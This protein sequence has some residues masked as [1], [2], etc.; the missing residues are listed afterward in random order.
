VNTVP[1]T[2]RVNEAIGALDEMSALEMLELMNHEDAGVPVAV[3]REIPA[4]AQAVDALTERL[5]ASG[6][7]ILVG[8][9]TSGRL[10]LMQTAEARP[11]FGIAVGT[12]VGIMAGGAD[13]MV[14]PAEAAEDD[15]AAGEEEL[16]RVAVDARDGVI[17]ISA[18]GRTHFVVGALTQARRS[19]ALT[20]GLSCDHPSPLAEAADIAIHPLVGP[21]VIAGSTRL[22]AGTAQKLVLDMIT[23]AVMVRLGMVHG[24]LMVGVQG[25]NQ[26]LRQRAGRIVEQVTGQSGQPVE[27]AL[28][29]AEWS[30]RQAIVML[31]RGVDAAE[32]RRLIDSGRPLSE[33]I[34]GS[35]QGRTGG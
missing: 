3:G 10:A 12:V 8:A 4:I 6:R 21:E 20:V 30:A 33:L 19:G 25:T 13:A 26:K 14:R 28:S 35:G 34:G 32:A 18:S 17:G 15:F 1:A 7:L 31:V 22:K 11:T 24:G 9:G 23:T 29:A 16:R 2:E 27:D 5:R